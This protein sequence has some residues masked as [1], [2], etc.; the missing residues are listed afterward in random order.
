MKKIVIL[1]L[2][3]S[4]REGSVLANIRVRFQFP[5]GSNNVDNSLLIRSAFVEGANAGL[6]TIDS[7]KLTVNGSL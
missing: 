6:A 7:T 1:F 5:S 4:Y 2:L 3:L